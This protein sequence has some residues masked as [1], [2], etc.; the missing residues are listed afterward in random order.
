[1]WISILFGLFLIAFA[2]LMLGQNAKAWRLAATDEMEE[3]ERDF[4][5]RQYRRR[6]QANWMIAVIG[7]AVIVG[8]WVTEPLMAAAYWLGVVLVVA[9]MALLAVADVVAT[10]MYYGRLRQEHR[11]ERVL[12]EAELDQ[13]KR[14]GSNG[15]PKNNPLEDLE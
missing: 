15:K 9:W 1:M 5:Y 10:Q 8:V 4:R 13:V 11:D 12:L 3:R 7:L 2:V 6:L 14:R